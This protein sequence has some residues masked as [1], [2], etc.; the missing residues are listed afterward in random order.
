MALTSEAREPELTVWDTGARLIGA[1][2]SG[3][4]IAAGIVVIF[5]W[6][7]AG[8]GGCAQS[9]GCPPDHRLQGWII[10]AAFAL[11]G[12]WVLFTV[13]RLRP[14]VATVPAAALSTAVILAGLGHSG[15]LHH[16]LV[17]LL[18]NAAFYVAIALP[19]VL[20][21]RRREATFPHS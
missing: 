9:G 10:G 19:G 6:A 8:S 14:S 5:G 16:A 15:R 2:A 21:A 7:V 3:V 13:F 17:F 18:L 4:G 12:I 11:L 20:R 1:A